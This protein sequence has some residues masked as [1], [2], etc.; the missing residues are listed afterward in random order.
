MALFLG[1]DAGTQGAKALVWDA[2]AGRVLG[3]GAASYGLLPAREPGEAE[4]HPWTWV[5]GVEAAIA[6]ALADPGVDAGAIRGLAVSGQQHGCVVLDEEGEVVRPAKLWC[7]TSTAAEAAELAG[8]LGRPLPAG[9]TASKLLWL[10]RR[11]PEHFARVRRVLLPHDYLNLHFSGEAVAEAG[12]ASGTGYFD[13]ERREWDAR[14]AAAIDD[15]LLARLPR[16]VGPDEPVGRVRP[17]LAARLGLPEDLLVAPGSG[18]NM[19]SALGAGAVREGVLVM[20]LGTSGTLFGR[21]ERPVIDPEGAIAPFCDAAGAWLPLLCT[22]NCT[23]VTE[24]VRAAFG[25]PLEELTAAAAEV[26]PGCDGLRFLPYLAGERS[27][28]WPHASGVLHGLRPGGLRPGP[29]FR[30]AMEGAAFALLLGHERLRRF[31]VEADELRVVGGASR[32]PVWRRVLADAFQLPLR[33]PVEAESAALGAAMQA[34]AVWSKQPVAAFVSAQEPPM[35]EERVKPDAGAR[36]A[37]A[38]AFDD[39]R[40]LG[41]ELFG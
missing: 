35:S 25:L 22:M 17:E 31:G 14:A 24:E 21:A 37:Y 27:P 32:N 41:R 33:F 34:A 23:T 26:A 8:A 29:L 5:E 20:S 28:D 4:Q 11:E 10:K 3:R 36:A 13:P 19:M 9:Y 40:R 6:Q 12:D 38:A 39:F 30:A 18:D 7:D 1:L 16:L 15:G 2:E